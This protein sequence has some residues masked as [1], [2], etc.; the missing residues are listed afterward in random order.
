MNYL[1]LF[2][3]N[4]ERTACTETQEY[5]S[6]T[7]ETDKVHI[8][9]EQFF[10]KLTLDNG[11]LV[12]IEGSGELTSA[13]ISAY[14]QTMVTAEIGN[15]CTSI[16]NMAF[17]QCNALTNV[18][19][20]NSVTICGNNAFM[21]CPALTNVKLS[22]KLEE[23][24]QTFAYCYGLQ[25]ITIPNKV[26]IL[27]GTFSGCRSLQN[28]T[29]SK[30]I[31]TTSNGA[32]GGCSGLTS[33]TLYSKVTSIGDQDFSHCALTSITSLAKTAPT[34]GVNVF[35]EMTSIGTLYVPQGSSGYDA[36]LAALP[37]GW[38]IVEQ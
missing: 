32:F 15:L 6:Y 12:E 21:A 33:I 11:D 28:I 9:E 10:L 5:V 36:W 17:F 38:T 1:K 8:H 13:I 34:L 7:E 25:S 37:S 31:T 30:N 29:L 3:T 14:Q 23:L 24:N 18:T 27:R 2:N 19:M 20:A 35:Q 4:A 16:G 22:E 26:T